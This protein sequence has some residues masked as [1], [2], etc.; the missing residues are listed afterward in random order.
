MSFRAESPP[1]DPYQAIR[2]LNRHVVRYVIVG[3]MAAAMYGSPSI[4]GDL[5]VC[6]AR[7][8]DNLSALAAALREMN[9]NERGSPSSGAT[10]RSATERRPAA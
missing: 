4:T 7:D 8:R 2:V 3:G 6:Y 5:D 10:V 9:A 1:F